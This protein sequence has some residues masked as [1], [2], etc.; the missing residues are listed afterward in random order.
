MNDAINFQGRFSY[1]DRI[2]PQGIA[3]GHLTPQEEVQSEQ[4][5]RE[6]NQVRQAMEQEE[7]WLQ[8]LS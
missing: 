4:L 7:G 5:K 3:A 2:Q 1:I 8:P 6:R